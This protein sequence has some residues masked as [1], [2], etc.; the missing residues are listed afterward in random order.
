MR[1]S[2][3]IQGG[4]LEHIIAA[5]GIC[6]EE[7]MTD[8]FKLYAKQVINN[9]KSFANKF[10]DLG[11]KVISNGTE[12]H[13]F[14]LDV[15]NSIGLTG[16]EVEVALDKINITVNKNQI[17]NDTLPPLKS[18]GIRLGTPAMTTK[19]WKDEDF[20]ILAEIINS[21]LLEVKANL[22]GDIRLIEYKEEVLKLIN[23]VKRRG[24][25]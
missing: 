4:P 11:Y 18:S 3:G 8:D 19:G 20:V 16:K 15:Y 17:P 9:A 24:E 23:S 14:V 22:I 1:Y 6:F 2:P 12:N 21:Y 7:A 13:M 5:K 10:I 25:Y